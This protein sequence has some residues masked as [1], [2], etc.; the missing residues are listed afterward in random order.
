MKQTS[1]TLLALSSLLVGFALLQMGNALQGTLL[2][3]RADIEGFSATITG[4]VMSGFFAGMCIGSLLAGKLIDQA[5][6]IRVFAALASLGS[7]AALIHLLWIDP[8]AW[9]IVRTVTGFCFAGLIIV[10]ESW[11]NAASEPE[12]R[13]RTLSLYSI[14]SMVAGIIG[15]LL[16]TVA[17]PGKFTLFVVVSVLMSIALVP[18]SLSK[19]TAPIAQGE[20]EGP[21]IKRLWEFSPFGAVAML[22][23]GATFGA[24]YGLV[25]IYAQ[26]IGFDQSQIALLMAAFV[27]GGVALQYPVGSLSDRINRRVVVIVQS[28][29]AAALLIG[30]ALAGSVSTSILLLGFAAIG[31]MILPT[32]SVI[33]AHVNDRAPATAIM[34]VAGGLVLMLGVGAVA[35]PVLGGLV[36]EQTG[37]AGLL[38]FIA[39]LQS[40]TAAYGLLRIKTVEG[41]TEEEKGAFTASP[42]TPVAAELELGV[43]EEVAIEA[44]AE[45]EEAIDQDTPD[46]DADEPNE[47][48]WAKTA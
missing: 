15:Q 26:R 22:L 1:A 3:V 9:I 42:I 38:L 23:L 13:G 47:S 17:E 2:A 37:P 33:I 29:L 44:E 10:V 43:Y 41:P 8:V 46:T 12:A 48:P 11:L 19:I 4:L 5:G 25:P 18:I 21:S 6:H 45:A 40:C 39:V 28:G 16:F 32:H 27:L 14:C 7:A 35:G 24:F 31:A 34:S 30:L 36:M 20:Q